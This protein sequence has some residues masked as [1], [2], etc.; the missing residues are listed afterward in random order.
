LVN[1]DDES[2]YL[3][4]INMLVFPNAKINLGLNILKKRPDGY[5]EINTCF[6]PVQWCDALEIIEA[7]EFKFTQT[8]LNIDGDLAD[9]LCVKAYQLLQQTYGLPHVSM[10]LHKVIPF[11]AGLGGGS[12]DAAF[13]LII[14]N[15]K[16]QLG[17]TSDQLKTHASV[18][19]SDCAFFIDNSPA[20]G[21]G[22][23]NELSSIALIL[24][25]KFLFIVKPDIH[26]NTA[27]AYKAV[28]PSIPEKSIEEILK[29]PISDWKNFLVNDFEYAVFNKYP[30]IKLIKEKLYA[31]GAQY[32]SMSG[33]GAAVF[34]FF[35]KEI[36]L[37]EFNSYAHWGGFAKF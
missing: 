18:L 34:G 5:H 20:I 21:K 4:S 3:F 30:E 15:E 2:A 23:G 26:I 22:I 17:L 36:E 13:T 7:D 6:Y 1:K 12:A 11:G 33:S 14:L 24:K 31:A 29:M 19:G 10:H 25:G 28:S 27:E 32:A 8:G 35:E 16:F 9:N 37:T